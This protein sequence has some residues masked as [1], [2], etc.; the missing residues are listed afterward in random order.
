MQKIDHAMIRNF[1]TNGVTWSKPELAILNRAI[2]MYPEKKYKDKVVRCAKIASTLQSKTIRDV[3]YK[4]IVM[5][6]AR[7]RA[8]AFR[9]VGRGKVQVVNDIASPAADEMFSLLQVR[10]FIYLDMQ[11][12]L[13][14]CCRAIKLR[15]RL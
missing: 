10:T 13:M 6:A 12:E 1:S 2:S 15:W 14:E 11:Y 4:I 7:E 3:A 8:A 5:R 9:K